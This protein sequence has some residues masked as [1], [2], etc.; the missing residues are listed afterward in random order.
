MRRAKNFRA[1]SYAISTMD[2]RGFLKTSVLL[3]APLFIRRA[4]GD[5]SVP[6]DDGGEVALRAGLERA[7]RSASQALVLV[8]PEKD[9]QKWERG[10]AF[11]EWLNH[12]TDA[13]LAPLAGYE[14]VCATMKAVRKVAEVSGEPLMVTIDP[15]TGTA[16]ALDAKLPA[17]DEFLGESTSREARNRREEATARR[18]IAT[19]ARLVAAPLAA[20]DVAQRARQVRETLVHGRVPGAKWANASGC[21]TQIEGE[22]GPDVSCGMGHVPAKSHRFLYFATRR[23]L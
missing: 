5:Q 14:V 13:E 9:G 2:R 19:L 3:V 8:V 22:D 15:R 7:R 21:G 18:R 16:R 11:G 1:A 17:Y 20:G 4:F 12:G 23:P 10:R 6:G